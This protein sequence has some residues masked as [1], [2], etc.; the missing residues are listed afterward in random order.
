MQAKTIK[1]RFRV[2]VTSISAA[3]ILATL[4]PTA[5][6]AGLKDAMNS[7]FVATST[8]PQAIETQRL[9]GVYGGSMSFRSPGRSINIMQFAPPRIDAGCGGVDIFFGSFSFINGAQFEQLLRSIAANAV[10][11][12][13]KAAIGAMCNPCGAILGELEKAIRELNSLAKNT[14][15]IANSLVNGGDIGGK[16]AESAGK[17]GGH[18]KSALSMTSDWVAGEN[19]RQAE[20]PQK[21]AAAG[22]GAAADNN[23]IIGNLVWRAAK[24]TM[25]SGSNTLSAFLSP[26]EA[27][28]MVQGL[29]G[30]VI[31]KPK[32]EGEKCTDATTPERCDTPP[33]YIPPTITTWNQLLKPKEY[34][35][36][37]VSILKCLNSDCT[38]VQPG[39]LP[40]WGG[41]QDAINLA[42][43]GTVNMDRR[44]EWTANSLIG[45]FHLKSPITNTSQLPLAAKIIIEELGFPILNMLIEVQ[46]VPGAPETLGVLVAKALP[47]YMDHK[48]A[49]ELQSIGSNAFSA[50]TKTTMPPEYRNELNLK[51]A[52]LATIAPDPADME[53]LADAAYKSIIR[54]RTLA[55]SQYRGGGS[56][57]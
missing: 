38:R 41:T 47:K 18:I 50:Q 4:S 14:C 42:L 32:E 40:Q 43:F 27:I 16:L 46:D 5:A 8:S 45:S 37:G 33:V 48:L 17:I 25:S 1:N 31:L 52:E 26:N 15:A 28:E 21:T 22:G 10:G 57:K 7:M 34:G 11:F 12:A 24:E 13:V 53:K 51:A 3:S 39:V 30:T 54:N 49:T 23:P 9:R 6:N 2:I 36:G 44:Y 56:G 29:Y 55:N 20:T 35:P 19:Q